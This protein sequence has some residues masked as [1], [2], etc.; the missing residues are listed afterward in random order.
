MLDRV[1][2]ILETVFHLKASE[3]SEELS[4]EKVKEWNSL[5]HLKLIMAIEQEFGVQFET[6]II[7][8]LNSVKK[9]HEALKTIKGGPA[10]S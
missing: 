7:P 6:E 3:I 5:N 10:G 4:T 9:I 8:E 2:K 1:S